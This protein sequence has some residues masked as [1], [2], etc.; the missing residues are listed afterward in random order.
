M[1]VVVVGATGNVGTAVL[2]RLQVEQDTEVVGVVRQVPPADAPPPY[3]D[4]V[5]HG[6]DVAAPSSVAALTA[7]FAGADAVIHLPWLLQPNHDEPVMAATNIGGLKHVLAAVAAARVPQAVVVSS[8][9][10]YSPGPKRR[11]V[12]ESWP[13]GGLATSHYSRHKAVNERILDRFEQDHPE[14]VVARLRPGLVMQGLVG[15]EL[16]ALFAGPLV[17]VR[18]IGRIPLGVLP[19]PPRTVSQVVH[20]DDLADAFAR[21]VLRRAA[22]AFNIAAEPVI[23]PKDVAAVM[24]ARWLPIRIAP[25]RGLVW[26]AWHLRLVAVDPGWIDIAVSV[27]L[28][29]TRRAREEL[30]W[31]PRIDAVAALSEAVRGVSDRTTTDGSPHLGGTAS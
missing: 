20:A 24:K 7:A 27:P 5:W 31:E 15:E 13:T 18:W 23:G 17:P 3:R 26:L 19:L 2:R 14:I 9:G 22:G 25:L 16:R 4:V 8:V 29:S 10:A 11:R 1:R 28:M 12:D 6:I 21:T 30:G